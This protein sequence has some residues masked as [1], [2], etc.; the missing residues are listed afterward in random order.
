[1]ST[2]QEER[3]C[4]LHGLEDAQTLKSVTKNNWICDKNAQPVRLGEKWSGAYV[5]IV[6]QWLNVSHIYCGGSYM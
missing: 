6:I 1:M 5:V 4:L 3:N 2:V